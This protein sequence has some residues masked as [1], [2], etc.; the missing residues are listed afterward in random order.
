MKGSCTPSLQDTSIEKVHIFPSP[1]CPLGKTE[2][3]TGSGA[4]GGEHASVVAD[5]SD[6]AD[7]TA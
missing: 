4:V 2:S 1:F 7:V 3:Q 6:I 5:I